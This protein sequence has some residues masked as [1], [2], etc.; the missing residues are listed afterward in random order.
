MEKADHH[1]KEAKRFDTLVSAFQEAS[2]ILN[3][4]TKTI[5]KSVG[6]PRNEKE[7]E[8]LLEIIGSMPEEFGLAELK[9]AAKSIKLDIFKRLFRD[10]KK[11][12]EVKE[13]VAATGRRDGRYTRG[14]QNASA[15]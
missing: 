10:M 4:E 13:L 8:A 1:R 2:I 3:G 5:E 15:T 7:R 14:S 9:L 11:S 12:G 6:R